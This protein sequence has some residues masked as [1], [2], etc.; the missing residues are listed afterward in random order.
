MAAKGVSY[1]FIYIPTLRKS[2]HMLDEYIDCLIYHPAY[3]C[4]YGLALQ[5]QKRTEKQEETKANLIRNGQSG[6]MT[7][8]AAKRLRQITTALV[9]SYHPAGSIKKQ[10]GKQSKEA[11]TFV[12]L[13]LPSKQQHSDKT[14]KRECLDQFIKELVRKDDVTAYIWRAEP[15]K[16]GNIHFH[17]VINRM[18]HWATIRL[19]WNRKIEKLGYIDEYSQKFSDMKLGD[20]IKYTK[21]TTT[22]KIAQAKR[23]Y[24][25][26]VNTGWRNPNSTDIHS[27]SKIENLCSY[28]VK[29]MSKGDAFRKIEG[30]I[31]GASTNLKN[32]QSRTVIMDSDWVKVWHSIESTP[33]FKEKR[34]D[35]FH[36]K[37]AKVYEHI[38][39]NHPQVWAEIQWKH[40]EDKKELE[41][42]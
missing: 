13:T 37:L 18:V 27:I 26:G 16:N 31:W 6:F 32:L 22:Q 39:K 11:I 28:V 40:A 36:I 21:A 23:A 17:L 4:R 5:K 3:L 24:Q 1:W 15:Q 30:A 12:T 8:G 7:P 20:Y 34:E 2:I 14:I 38:E 33:G 19:N 42:R 9:L 29:Y 25:Y 41:C 10:N 35:R